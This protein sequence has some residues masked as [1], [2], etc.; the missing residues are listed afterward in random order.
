MNVTTTRGLIP[1][2]RAPQLHFIETKPDA[3]K[4]VVALLHGYADHAARYDHV[5]RYFANQ[6]IHVIAL[7][8]RGHG[9]SDGPR[10]YCDRF[11]DFVDDVAELQSLTAARAPGVPA[12]LFGHSFGGLL[13]AHIGV[14]GSTFFR[15]YVLSAPFLAL[16]LRVSALKV[17]AG[18]VASRIVPRL[19]LPSGLTGKDLTHDEARARAYDQDPLVFK[20]A[21][22]RWFTETQRAQ[23]E[24]LLGAKRLE[25]PLFLAFGTADSVASFPT[26]KAFF[27]E[28]GASDKVFSPQEGLFHEI[29]NEPGWEPI[30]AEMS[31]FVLSRAGT[32][33]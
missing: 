25:K 21:T 27:D 9:G 8:L 24:V 11:S 12:F 1:R 5:A 6:S 7:D 16:A 2:G 29:L 13:A 17:A 4:A 28:V 10:G 3:P 19:G 23:K 22:A 32:I 30:A 33:A 15:G 14:S 18:K 26:G 31:R 20:N